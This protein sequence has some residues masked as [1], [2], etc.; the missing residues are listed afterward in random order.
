MSIRQIIPP[1]AVPGGLIRIE[2]DGVQDPTGVQVEIGGVKA[3]LLGASPRVLMARIPEEAGNGVLVR[4]KEE[5]RGELRVGQVVASDLHPVSNPVVDEFGNVYVTYSGSRGEKVPFSL[6]LVDE[7]GTKQPFLAEITNPTGL[8]IGPDRH[9]YI[10]SRHTGA[11]YRSTF[12]KQVEKYV[13]GLGLS[14]GLAFDSGGNLFVG[15]RS[16]MIYK[17]TPSKELTVFCELEPSVSAYHLVFGQGDVLY[18]T[19]ATLATQDCIYRISSEGEVGIFYKGLGRPQ[20]LAFSPDGHLQV[21]ASYRGRRGLY[22]FRDGVPEFTVSGPMFVGLAYHPLGK[23]LYL[24][25][26]RR[27]YRIDLP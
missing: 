2:V 11:I 14:T 21:V 10:T 7:E 26:N 17:V 15:D 8:V 3:D 1:M 27:L 16:G 5:A 4:E 13:D 22:T 24:V 9:L 25:D 23:L 19:G 6:F 20:G 18:V 12:D